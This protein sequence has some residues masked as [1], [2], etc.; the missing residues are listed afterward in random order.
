MHMKQDLNIFKE[1]ESNFKQIRTTVHRSEEICPERSKRVKERREKRETETH[2][3]KHRET[4]RG[5]GLELVK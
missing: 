3:D 5:R 1:S 2:I 4:E